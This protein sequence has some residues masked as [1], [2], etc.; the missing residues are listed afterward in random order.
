[1]SGFKKM[2]IGGESVAGEQGVEPIVSINPATGE[3]NH[4]VAAAGTAAVD[5][6]VRVADVAWRERGWRSMLPAQ[7]GAVLARIAVGMERQSE[8]LARL[9]MLENGKVWAECQ[10]QVKSAAATFR[11]YAAVCETVGSEVTPSRGDYLSMSVYEPV[12]VVAAITPWNSPMT[13]EAQKLAPALAAGNAVVLKPSEVTP[14]T[15]LMLAQI[16]HER[17]VHERHGKRAAHRR[18]CGPQADAG[19]TGVGRQIAAHRVR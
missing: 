6:A 4:E 17:V 9:Q 3:I 16:A 2:W 10:A 11:Y 7:R 18:N 8:A 5:A 13:M 19:S 14:S 1:M 15:A 12:G